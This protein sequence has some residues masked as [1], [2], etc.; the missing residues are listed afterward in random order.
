VKEKSEEETE[1]R[2]RSRRKREMEEVRNSLEHQK[3]KKE[4]SRCHQG[5]I[6]ALLMR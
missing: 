1:S 3:E 4:L 6:K 2:G 5:A